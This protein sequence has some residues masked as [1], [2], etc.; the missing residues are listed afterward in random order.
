MNMK[1]LWNSGWSGLLGLAILAMIF[2]SCDDDDDVDT[3]EM[4]PVAFVS[5]YQASPDAPPLDIMVNGNTI[6][7]YPF[8]YTDYTGY[9]RFFTGERSISFGP[10]DANN[11]VIDT[12]FSLEDDQAYSLFLA[13]DYP[14]NIEALL[15]EDN[16]EAP[17]TG[18]AM[19]RLV[20][21]SPDVT[22]IDFGAKDETDAIF[23]DQDFKEAPTFKSLNAERYNFQVKDAAGDSVLLEIPNINL[24]SGYYY[25]VIVRGYQNPPAGTNSDLSAQVIV[26]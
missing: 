8:D 15:F 5:M 17:A 3:I 21:L 19:I 23:D 20:N 26:N 14:N 9:L 2:V 7:T 10:S 13:G 11:V 6:N 22:T 16:A 1:R 25:T 12:T 24:T 4:E 18:N